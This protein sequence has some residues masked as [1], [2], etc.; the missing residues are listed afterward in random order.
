MDVNAPKHS[1]FAFTRYSALPLDSVDSGDSSS[2]HVDMDKVSSSETPAAETV[3]AAPDKTKS[4]RRPLI[5]ILV[6]VGVVTVLALGLGLGL[7][8]GL[9]KVRLIHS[10][11]RGTGLLTCF[12]IG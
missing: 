4:R 11:P 8:Y 6:V 9:R 2:A 1:A 7:Y 10:L 3:L 5:I 12:S